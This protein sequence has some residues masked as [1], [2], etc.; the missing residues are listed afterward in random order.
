MTYLAFRIAI[1]H[2]FVF[3]NDIK[4]NKSILSMVLLSIYIFLSIQY[5]SE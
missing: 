3:I 1:Y 5:L 2:I 4:E